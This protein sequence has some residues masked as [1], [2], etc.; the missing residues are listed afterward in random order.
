[1]LLVTSD[2]TKYEG[3]GKSGDKVV[4]AERCT[5]CDGTGYYY[6]YGVCFSCGGA[7]KH[8]KTRKLYTPE[9][10]QKLESRK[11][12]QQFLRE[13]IQAEYIQ[14]KKDKVESLKEKHS[15]IWNFIEKSHD[16]FLCS[17]KNQLLNGNEFSKKQIELAH[18]VI[19]EEKEKPVSKH[20]GEIGERRDFKGKIIQIVSGENYWG[21]WQIATISCDGNQIV[22]KGK[23]HLGS[24]GD[25]IEFKATVKGWNYFRDQKQTEVN[26]PKLKETK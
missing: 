22:Y 17:L 21:F 20:I 3:I 11:H 14:T 9:Q 2:G 6:H 13:Q 15:E 4:I 1:M 12:E 8:H 19:L 7:G 18:K 25:E 5:K 23:S 26:R 10:Q 24:K 16:A